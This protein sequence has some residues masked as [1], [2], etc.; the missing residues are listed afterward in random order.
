MK[1]NRGFTLVELL[2]VIGI[3]ALLISILLP[4]LARAREKA[5]QIKCMANLRSIG[6]AIMLYANDNPRTPFPKLRSDA[7]QPLILNANG[8]DLTGL[9]TD[10][11]ATAANAAVGLNNVPGALFLLIR[12]Q[13]IGSE[14]FTCPS[15]SAERDTY[16]RM[17]FQRTA[18]DCGNFGSDNVANNTG[19][20]TKYLSYGL[21]N[22]YPN[23]AAAAAGFRMGNTNADMALMADI[24]P[25]A[26]DYTVTSTSA[27][28]ADMKKINSNNHGKE[29]QNVLYADGHVS[30]ETNPFVG[31]KRNQIYVSDTPNAGNETSRTY[32]APSQVM[33]GGYPTAAYPADVN[34]TVCLPWGN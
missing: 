12:T 4:S 3:I 2:V 23:A 20:V 9:G 10:P 34:D 15:S 24:G 7:A 13:Q 17:T 8:A 30:W 25:A 6:Q 27:S 11:F 19:S 33:T 22:P 32:P 16:M 26:P 28:A 31:A 5:N 14:V 1:R 21:G 18:M 29:G